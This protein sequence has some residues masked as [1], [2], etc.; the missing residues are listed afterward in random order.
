M[1]KSINQSISVTFGNS[2]LLSDIVSYFDNFTCMFEQ[3]LNDWKLLFDL[4]RHSI[5]CVH[6]VVHSVLL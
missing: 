6:K 4:L 1:K 5:I 2:P 3:R